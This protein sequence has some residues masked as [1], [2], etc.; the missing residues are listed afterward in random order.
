MVRLLEIAI[1][2]GDEEALNDLGAAYLFGAYGLT[3]NMEK[4]EDL[5]RKAMTQGCQK[6]KMNL[7]SLKF[8]QKSPED[9]EEACKLFQELWGENTQKF[10]DFLKMWIPSIKGALKSSDE[11]GF[12]E[13]EIY[14][15]E[16]ASEDEKNEADLQDLS[17]HQVIS[18]SSTSPLSSDEEK[19]PEDYWKQYITQ[20]INQ[21]I[22]E[23]PQ[24]SVIILTR[25][26]KEQQ[27]EKERLQRKF[28]R[29]S[30]R[31]EALRLTKQAKYRKIK[32]LMNQHIE[33]FGGAVKNGKGSGRRV[34]IGNI[35]SG[36]HQ[37][38]KAD[39]KGGA[40]KNLTG[41]FE[42]SSKK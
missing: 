12:G 16:M 2:G 17:D 1:D 25:K 28:E 31:V 13:E 41:C 24:S 4:A 38:H 42:E 36:F 21:E 39:I 32:T 5:L 11:E 35:H 29:L 34:E 14:A 37:P 23:T 15:Q 20:S 22:E 26:E 33:A 19:Y 18:N 10:K 8:E 40:L 9:K 30:T 3:P 6:A 7:M 27:E